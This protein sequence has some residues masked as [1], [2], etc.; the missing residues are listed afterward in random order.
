M[1]FQFLADIPIGQG[2]RDSLS[3]NDD[4]I[5]GIG[6]PIF[7]KSKE[8]SDQTLETIPLYCAARFFGN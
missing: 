3:G 7:M 2:V 1:V 5:L 6:D 8:L 4:D